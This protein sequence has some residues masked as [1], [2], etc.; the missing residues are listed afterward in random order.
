MKIVIG[1]D[2]YFML[3]AVEDHQTPHLELSVTYHM[4]QLDI[5]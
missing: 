1:T 3:C 2:I 4:W 5:S